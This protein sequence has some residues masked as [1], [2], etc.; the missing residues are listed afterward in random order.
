MLGDAAAVAHF[1]SP[2]A[3]LSRDA[4]AFVVRFAGQ[5][6]AC[7]MTVLSGGSAGVYW[8]ATR[9]DAR[10]RGF[11]ELATRAAVRAGFEYG[12]R[13]VTLQSTEQGV[14]LYRKLGFAPFTTYPRYVVPGP[15]GPDPGPP[16]LSNPSTGGGRTLNSPPIVR[17]EES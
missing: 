15:V 8:V 12:A 2:G 16:P 7:A 10:R 4:V 5:P 1:A 9:A 17:S 11:G 13:V 6:V 3:L 14:P